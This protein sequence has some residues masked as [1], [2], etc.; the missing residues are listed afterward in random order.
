MTFRT[1]L[2]SQFSGCHWLRKCV[3]KARQEAHRAGG[4]KKING[5]DR[6]RENEEPILW[7]EKC[8]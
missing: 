6:R 4:P 8:G 2:V 3:N 7:L 1:E 5:T